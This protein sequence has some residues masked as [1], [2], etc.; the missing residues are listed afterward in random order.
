MT[1]DLHGRLIR[2]IVPRVR[3]QRRIWE[4]SQLAGQDPRHVKEILHHDLPPLTRTGESQEGTQRGRSMAKQAWQIPQWSRLPDKRSE[5]TLRL[6]S[7]LRIRW[8][9][10]GPGLTFGRARSIR[11]LGALSRRRSRCVGADHHLAPQ[12]R[13][14]ST[15]AKAA[16]RLT[17]G[18]GACCAKRAQR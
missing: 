9:T 15:Q 5:G 4:L 18:A 8:T 17:A 2:N 3:V 6:L 11:D 10:P 1:R 14:P 16:C 13:T 12:K 7:E